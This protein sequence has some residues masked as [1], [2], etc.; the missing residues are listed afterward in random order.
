MKINLNSMGVKR[1]EEEERRRRLTG[2]NRPNSEMTRN[3]DGE[4]GEGEVDEI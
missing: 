2:S 1:S 4:V 3:K